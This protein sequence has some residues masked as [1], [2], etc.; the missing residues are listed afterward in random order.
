MRRPTMQEWMDACRC[1]AEDE[2]YECRCDDGPEN[3]DWI[4]LA[5]ERQAEN[6]EAHYDGGMLRYK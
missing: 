4:A 2:G 1:G 6:R 5:Y 3:D